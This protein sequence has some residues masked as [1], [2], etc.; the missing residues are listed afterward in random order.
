LIANKEADMFPNFAGT[1]QKRR[2]EISGDQLTITNPTGASGGILSVVL[3][4]AK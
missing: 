3:K 2:F 4:R 1:T